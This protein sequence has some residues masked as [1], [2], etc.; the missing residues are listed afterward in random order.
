M[1]QGGGGRCKVAGDALT[2]QVLQSR[3]AALVGNVHHLNASALVEQ[4]ASQVRCRASTRGCVIHLAGRLFG[5]RHELLQILHT[6]TFV[7][8][9][10]VGEVHAPGQRSQ[11]LEGVV[12]ELHQ[13]RGNRQRAHGAKQNHRAIGHRV[14]HLPM[15]NVAASTALV[16]HHHRLANVFSQ[17]LGNQPGCS[18]GSTAWCKADH[19]GD[20]LFGREVLGQNMA[21]ECQ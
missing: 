10:H 14:G 2:Q 20:G 17:L 7:R 12:V 19:H 8:H 3:G 9:Q 16:F 11:I 21:C 6:C 15:G 1:G 13:V 5:Q 4:L 18:I